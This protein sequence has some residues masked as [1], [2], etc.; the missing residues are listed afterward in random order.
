MAKEDLKTRERG[1]D[2]RCMLKILG[3]AGATVAGISNLRASGPAEGGEEDPF[4]ILIDTTRCAGCRSCEFACAEANGLPEPDLDEAVLDAER[5]TSVTQWNVVNRFQTDA[6]EIYAK[7][8]CMHCVQPACASACL[9]KAMLKT[10]EGP[11]VWR[12]E[13]C[14]G[15]RFCMISC[16]FDVPKFEYDS[17]NPRIQKC[18]LCWSRVSQGELP[19]CVENCPA[20]A[21]MFDRRAKLLEEARRR[22]YENPDQYFHGIYGE[23]EA[24]GTSA[25]YLSSV[26]FDQIGFRTDLAKESYPG[27][28][29]DFLYGVPVVL[30]VLPAFLLALSQATKREPETEESEAR[31]EHSIDVNVRSSA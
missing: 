13:K 22:I 3:T 31:D 8:Q 20:E 11:V 27:L 14:M 1:V 17:A 12:G 15:C 10:R 2:R 29:E 5:R 7:R 18:R 23:H 26:P 21:L 30:T 19:A 25:L 16:P 9:T 24:G 4:G 28:T 6:G